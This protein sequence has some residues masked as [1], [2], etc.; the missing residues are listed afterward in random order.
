ME[1]AA[2]VDRRRGL[3]EQRRAAIRAT[4]EQCLGTP[5]CKERPMDGRFGVLSETDDGPY[6]R[7]K[8]EYAV[9]AGETVRAYLLLPPKA[10]RHKG[11][12]VL[13]LHET[14]ELGKE[15]QIGN[16]GK[17]GRDLGK[18]LAER[19]Y[20]VLAP[21]HEC[22]GE[23]IQNG[24]QAFDTKPFYD[25]HPNWSMV[26]KA[27]WDGRCALD[28]LSRIDGVDPARLG[29]AG[30]S[31]GGHGAVFLAA[32]DDRVKA[33]ASS[34]GLT[35]W[36]GDPKRTNWSRDEWYVYFP[37]LHDPLRG[38]DPLPFDMHEFASLVAPRALLNV[39][40]MTDTI[41]GNM[42]A[43]PEAGRQLHRLWTLLGHPAGFANFLFGAGHDAPRYSR[44]AITGWFD[45]WLADEPV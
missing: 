45:H 14:N 17:P 9:A 33:A 24:F 22:A 44:W 30:H 12:A 26:G 8:I 10:K 5:S 43:L 21:D 34:C 35:I 16:G 27:I 31:L 25:R 40:G 29:V 20:I 41:Y 28:V 23:R 2:D 36:E 32:F 4:I 38:S 7:L 42:Q 37:R 18:L 13:A 3:W 19:G 39:S 6:R 15:T 1:D 11:A